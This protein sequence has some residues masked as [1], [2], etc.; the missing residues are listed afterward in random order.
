M[1][2]IFLLCKKYNIIRGFESKKAEVKTVKSSH[3]L[4][5]VGNAGCP[6]S[7]EMIFLFLQHFHTLMLLQKSSNCSGGGV[8]ASRTGAKLL[9]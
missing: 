3:S 4:P 6:P 8:I 5:R 1:E 7:A 9:R 2:K